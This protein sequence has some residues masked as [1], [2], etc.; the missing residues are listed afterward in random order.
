MPVF[1]RQLIATAIHNSVQGAASV[2]CKDL[3]WFCFGDDLMTSTVNS[4]DCAVA[5]LPYGADIAHKVRYE[6]Q[7]SNILKPPS[8]YDQLARVSRH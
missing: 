4:S 2:R 3:R 8:T 6:I 1:H 5:L 7:L